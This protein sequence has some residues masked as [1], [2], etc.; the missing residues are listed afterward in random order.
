MAA[1][2][3][4]RVL[5]MYIESLPDGGRF[6]EEARRATVTTPIVALKVGRSASGKRA[7][8]SHTGALAGADIAYDSA[9]EK[10]GVL[11][12]SSA[13][14]L[15]GMVARA[16]MAASPQRTAP[17]PCSRMQADLASCRL[18]SLRSTV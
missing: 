10:A 3:Q 9:F 7:A 13:E 15:F 16:R 6:I 11:R 1:D 18:T 2:K 5:A 4:T 8:A 17:W 12:V 14:E